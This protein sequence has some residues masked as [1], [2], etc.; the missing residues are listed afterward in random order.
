MD[1][2]SYEK[3]KAQVRKKWQLSE[4]AE[5]DFYEM[6]EKNPCQHFFVYKTSQWVECRNCHWGLQVGV[7]DSLVD[8]HLYSNGQKV[9]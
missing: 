5:V 2:K 8:G 6:G 1:Q 9:L 3:E 4:D 7:N